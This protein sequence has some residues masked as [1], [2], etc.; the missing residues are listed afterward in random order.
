[1]LAVL[2]GNGRNIITTVLTTLV[3]KDRRN[4]SLKEVCPS[5]PSTIIQILQSSGRSTS[6]WAANTS[7]TQSM[8]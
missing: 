3:Y 1:M 8:K 4:Q 6:P 2:P 7:S 5:L